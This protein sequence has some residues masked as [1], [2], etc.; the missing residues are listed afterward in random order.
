MYAFYFKCTILYKECIYLISK[1]IKIIKLHS[2]SELM[3]IPDAH[4]TKQGSVEEHDV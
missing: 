2:S 3:V 1:G 4:L